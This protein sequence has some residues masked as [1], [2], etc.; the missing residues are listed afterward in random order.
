MSANATATARVAPSVH[1]ATAAS[2]PVPNTARGHRVRLYVGYLIAIAFVLGIFAYGFNY[3]TLGAYERPFS[4]KHALLKPSGAIGVKLGMLGLGMFLCIFLYP[5]RKN[6]AWLGRQGISRHWLDNHVL[7][8]LAA[9]FVIALHAAFKFRGFAGIAFWIMLAVAL[10]GV[11]GRYLYGQIPRSLNAAELSLKEVQDIQAQ[12]GEQLA[13]Q[14]ILPESDLGAVLSLP[15]AE[16]VQTLPTVVALVYMMLL[17]IS[18][19]F[20]IATLRRRH[21]SF[22][23]QLLTLGGL[24]P[25]KHLDLERAIALAREEASISKR[26][27]FLSCSQKVFHLWHVVHR[28]FSYTFALLAIVHIVLIAMMGYF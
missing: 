14:K 15:S 1:L 27:L 11:I 13:E 6:W 16:R 17:D 3:Y 21:L 19:V 12:L 20:K 22:G 26:V 2:K 10:S 28:P 7:L 25:T 8:G 23:E 24:L 18:R 4:P 9:P 5:L